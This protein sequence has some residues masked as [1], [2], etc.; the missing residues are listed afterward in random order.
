MFFVFFVR[1]LYWLYQF[2]FSGTIMYIELR[3]VKFIP[4]N[5]RNLL[6]HLFLLRKLIQLFGLSGAKIHL[7]H[8]ENKVDSV[9]KNGSKAKTGKSIQY[10]ECNMHVFCL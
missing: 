4:E 9:K 6:Y 1:Y 2:S 3:A 8:R 7:S 10:I 5:N